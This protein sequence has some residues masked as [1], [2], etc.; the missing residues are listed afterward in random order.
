MTQKKYQKQNM[1]KAL[2]GPFIFSTFLRHQIFLYTI[3][4]CTPQRFDLFNTYSH[5]LKD[6]IMLVIRTA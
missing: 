1:I 4:Y 2:Y 3:D 5:R 6:E